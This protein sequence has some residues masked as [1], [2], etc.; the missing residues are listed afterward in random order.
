MRARLSL[1]LTLFTLLFFIEGQRVFFS[2]LYALSARAL[3][4]S[5]RP[6]ALLFA[7][8]PLV[9][10]LLPMLPFAR[11]LGKRRALALAVVGCALARVLMGLPSFPV[12][13]FTSAVVVGCGALFLS[14]AIGYLERR[15]IAA[16]AALAVLADQVLRL[17]GWSYDPTLRQ[18][19]IPAQ[20]FEAILVMLVFLMWTRVPRT[21]KREARL[22][23]RAGGLR[24]RGAVAFAL[25]F[26][27]EMNA[28]AMP[29]VLARLAHVDYFAAGIL[30]CLGSIVAALLLL[31][32]WGPVGRHRRAAAILGAAASL[33]ILVAWKFSGWGVALFFA[34]GHAAALLLLGRSLVPAGGRRGGWTVSAGF[35]VLLG[36]EALYAGT[37]FYAFT[38]SSFQGMAPWLFAAA[39]VLLEVALVLIPRPN[40]S[41]PLLRRRAALLYGT[42]ATI[43]AVSAVAVLLASEPRA[44]S[45]ALSAAH[46]EPTLLRVATY[47]VHG[48]FSEDW[49]YDPESIARG[50]ER[51]NSDV[52][53][54][55][56]LPAGT[57]F[58][59]GTD[60]ALWLGHRLRMRADFAPAVNQLLGDAL[61]S[62]LPIQH[63]R[64]W[65]LRVDETALGRA[66]DPKVAIAEDV[67]FNGRPVAVYGARLD[68]DPQV[69]RLQMSH[70]IPAI[71]RT[72]PAVFMGDLKADEQSPAARALS[73]AGFT[74]A[75]ESAG[76]APSPTVPERVPTQ[77]ADW[78]WVRGFKART[79]YVLDTRG[80][81]HRLVAAELLLPDST[82]P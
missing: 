43:V 61:L 14:T 6:L 71:G 65:R 68:G 63:V 58:A 73:A 22:E 41:A 20:V 48:G 69:Q 67:L 23:R 78:I 70:I 56:E 21:E 42:T 64:S 28:L 35:M 30:L 4:P 40:R 29:E 16:G 44:V 10:F 1:T 79:A 57:P 26:F 25:I 18:L 9:V 32:A 2:T 34:F 36:F 50:V 62:R 11:W 54:L 80:S 19:W 74:D 45:R 12:R 3:L 51:T 39:G 55:Q 66:V 76:R 47:N 59:Y 72:G 8:A 38:F 46:T 31:T 27:L 82:T 15:S 13:L 7:I 75:F 81:D 24:L 60:L 77:R 5:I 33:A 17:F 52:V 49:R 37:F 53:A